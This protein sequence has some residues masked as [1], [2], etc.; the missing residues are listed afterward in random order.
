MASLLQRGAATAAVFLMVV[1]ASLQAQPVT[2]A[3]AGLVSFMEGKVYLDDRALDHSPAHFSEVSEKSVLRTDTGRAEVLLGPCAVLRVAENSSFRMLA[4]AITDPQ[5]ELLAGA[6]IVDVTGM[7]RGAKLTFS[8]ATAAVRIAKTGLYRFEMAPPRVKV[9]DGGATV[10]RADRTL[11]IAAGRMLAL[12]SSSPAEKFD[13]KMRD[14]LD[15]WSIQRSASLAAASG[16]NRRQQEQTGAV[17]SAADAAASV[18][19][20]VHDHSSDTYVIQSAPS[21]PGPRAVMVAPPRC[22]ASGR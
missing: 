4:N 22:E 5:I 12:D 17:A 13:S 1:P 10:Q 18:V 6:A 3:K 21:T 9:F 7:S 2:T 14:A 16:A 19:G 15:L 8:T 20:P 11:T